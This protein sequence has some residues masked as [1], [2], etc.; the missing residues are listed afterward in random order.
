MHIGN[1]YTLKEVIF[2]TRRDIFALFLISAIPTTLYILLGWRWLSIPWL[3]V[4]LLGTAVAFVVGFKNNASYDRLWEARKLWGGIVNVSRTW[5]VMVLDYVTNKHAAKALS[6]AD[7]RE[8]HRE[9]VY[10]HLAWLTALRYQLREYR[11]WESVNKKHNL[12]YRNKWFKVE[13]HNTDVGEALRPYL[14]AEE[15]AS[16]MTKTNKAA[17][18]LALQSA[19]LRRLL[20]N[21]YIEDFRHMELE[22]RIA[23]LYNLQGGCERIKNFPY[24]RQYATLNLWFVKAF[25]ILIPLGM[26]QEFDRFGIQF[27]W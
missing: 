9:L 7:L 6:A 15:H 17:Q 11:K 23:E 19:H 1:N 24:P 22:N 20:E 2:W 14:R 16:V 8:L 4:A 10:R 5:T 13:E 25:I 27:V 26:L 18:I 3:P 21:G 12:E